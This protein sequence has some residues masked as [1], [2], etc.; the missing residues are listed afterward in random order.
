MVKASMDIIKVSLDMVK[1]SIGV[2]IM[3]G[4]CFTII[5]T[6]DMT[7]IFLNILQV[8]LDMVTLSLDITHR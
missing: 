6:I 5:E 4:H 1:L 7:H 8:S 3:H 2:E